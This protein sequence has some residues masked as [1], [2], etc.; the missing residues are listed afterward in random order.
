MVN[1]IVIKKTGDIKYLNAKNV[2]KENLYK[3]AGLSTVKNFDREHTWL[4]NDTYYSVF[5]KNS[6]KAG[7]ENKFELPPPVDEN[8][9]F[10]NMVFIK[11]LDEEATEIVDLKS[12]DAN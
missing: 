10:G 4:I 12:E 1:I 5:A 11:H 8:L 6:G 7:S 9:Y 3:K 2:T